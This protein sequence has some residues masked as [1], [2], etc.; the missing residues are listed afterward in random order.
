MDNVDEVALNVLLAQGVDLPTALAAA[1]RDEPASEPSA[2][3]ATVVIWPW[4][5]VFVVVALGVLAV[6]Q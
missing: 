6:L 5:V 2:P 3:D 1:Q 4:V